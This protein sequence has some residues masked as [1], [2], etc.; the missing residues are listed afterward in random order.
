MTPDPFAGDPRL[1]LT[2]AGADLQIAGGQPLMDPG[3]ENQVLISLFTG[4]GWC[5]NQFL[6]PLSRIGSD[7]ELTCRGP[8]TLTRLADIANAAE[9]ALKSD[10]FPELAVDV[11]NP[12]SDHLVITITL[13]SGRVLTLNRKGLKWQAQAAYPASGRITA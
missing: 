6:P 2:P 3:L 4:E 8:I 13:G 11:K 5:G 10:Y 12:T 1:L 7:F 9:R